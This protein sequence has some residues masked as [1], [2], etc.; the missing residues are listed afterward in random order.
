MFGNLAQDIRYGLRTLKTNPGFTTVAVLTLALGI[1]TTT[2]VFSVVNGV[3]LSPLPFKEPD[4]LVTWWFSAPPAL[5]EYALTQGHFAFYRDQSQL[6]DYTSAYSPSSGF[7]LSG[8]GE[9]ERIQGAN[10]TLDFFRALGVEPILGRTFVAEEETPG[11]NVVCVLSYAFW[12]QRFGGDP[13]VLGK[14]LNLNDFPTEVVGVMPAGFE[15]PRDTAL[16]IPVGLNP[17]STGFFY[18]RPIARLKPGVSFAQAQAEFTSVLESFARERTDLYPEGVKERVVS[19]PLKDRIIGEV[20]KPLLILLGAVA[21]LLLIACANVANLL[22]AR[23]ARRTKEIALRFALGAGTRRVVSQLLTESLVLAMIG[24]AVGVILAVIGV[25]L[26]NK[27]P[28]EQVPRINE[29]RVD[30]G[31]I[32][33]TT[34]VA[35]LTGLLFGLAPAA[36]ASRVALSE[37]LKE[38]ARGGLSPLSGKVNHL[39]V[40]LQTAVSMILLIGSVLL[41][42]SAQNLLSVD[43]GFRS[44]NV[45]TLRLSLPSKR[46]PKPED[47]EAFYKQLLDRVSVLPGVNGAGLVNLRPLSGKAAE[48]FYTVEGDDPTGERLTALAAYRVATPGYF[49]A[50]GIGLLQGQTFDQ[51]QQRTSPL[52]A[53]VDEELARRNWPGESAIGKRLRRG[54]AA[55]TNQPWINIIGVVA[56][57]KD[58]SL[59]EDDAPHLYTPYTQAGTR[60]MELIIQRA[61]GAEVGVRDVQGVVAG[62]DPQLPLYRVQ[63]MN[64][65]VL[66]S[67]GTRLLI[68]RLLA[69]F[70]IIALVLAAVGIYG[71]MSLHVGSRFQEFGIRIALG[72]QS[73]DILSMVIKRAMVLSAIGVVV[74]LIASQGL[75]RFIQSELFGIGASNPGVLIVTALAVGLVALLACWVPAYR[76]T[77]ADPVVA[78][79]SE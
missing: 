72:A 40:V 69:A 28:V 31:V 12:Q 45:T 23:S 41:F 26:V 63:S 62:L 17:K 52:V 3:L 59:G 64:T 60:E 19:M 37:S 75:T 71:V 73:R 53:V 46:Y 38:G 77:R 2:A 10:V 25:G 30:L 20:R 18:L 66:N 21:F 1:G 78:L 16:W 50:L 55:D 32:V 15:F 44:E 4:R 34:G 36:A 65:A 33:F 49:E 57:V 56:T 39:L 68:N 5:P 9:P 58:A 7:N 6:L 14:S 54:R 76:A 24:A 29:A 43:S 8:T 79:R 35:V 67:L 42:L 74:G 51:S 47:S 11:K 61:P 22:L 48:G 27:L 70:A 13:Q